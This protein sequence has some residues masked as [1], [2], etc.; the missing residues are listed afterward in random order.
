MKNSQF[1]EIADNYLRSR[2]SNALVKIHFKRAPGERLQRNK[3]SR[4][5]NFVDPSPAKFD[6]LGNRLKGVFEETTTT[7]RGRND[8]DHFDD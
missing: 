1:E 6:K 2:V 5:F 8:D 3:F 4:R 7:T